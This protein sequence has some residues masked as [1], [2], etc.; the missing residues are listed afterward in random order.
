[1]DE[2]VRRSSDLRIRLE[3]SAS[4]YA[5]RGG[6][7]MAM[8]EQVLMGE[9]MLERLFQDLK[10][11]NGSETCPSCQA[12]LT[13]EQVRAGWS[14]DPND[15][16]TECRA[17]VDLQAAAVAAAAGVSGTGWGAGAAAGDTGGADAGSG[18]PA[19][20]PG[21][22]ESGGGAATSATLP[23]GKGG[24][25]GGGGASRRK[26]SSSSATGS[27]SSS[28]KASAS[29]GGTLVTCGRRFVSRFSV[30]STVEGWEGTTGPGTPLWCEY[31][32]PWVLRKEF[33]TILSAYGVQ[34]VCS[35]RFRR[36]LGPLED[37]TG[38]TGAGGGGQSQ[39]PSGGGADAVWREAGGANANRRSVDR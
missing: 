11:D 16:T 33:H 36:G 23:A 29:K 32:P 18:G 1:E 25:S 19:S 21:S 39:P 28:S 3:R 6:M 8:Q 17:V 20:R 30:H 27:S 9:K 24:G 38:P 31:L 5:R 13:G 12:E 2:D 14:S 35:E 7:S 34:Y 22:G 4:P 10:I 15:Y 26:S 37:S